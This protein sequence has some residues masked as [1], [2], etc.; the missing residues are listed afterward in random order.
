VKKEEL[1]FKTGRGFQE[2]TPVTM[3]RCK[4]RLLEHLILWNRD[5][6]EE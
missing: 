3:E 4:R 5:H 6:G 1:G 2:W